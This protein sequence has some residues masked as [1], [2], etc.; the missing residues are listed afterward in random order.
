MGGGGLNDFVSVGNPLE[1]VLDMGISRPSDLP[2]IA[3]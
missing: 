3:L 1:V 2:I